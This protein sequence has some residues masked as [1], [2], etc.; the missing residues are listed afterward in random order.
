M[1]NEWNSLTSWHKTMLDRLICCSNQSISQQYS[2][3]KYKWRRSYMSSI[4]MLM[5]EINV[6]AQII[7]RI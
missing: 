6:E 1:Y 4:P 3:I 5:T 7:A 2:N